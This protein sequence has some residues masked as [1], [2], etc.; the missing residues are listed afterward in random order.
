MVRKLL[1][2]DQYVL[3]RGGGI[4]LIVRIC[5]LCKML[6]GPIQQPILP[7]SGHHPAQVS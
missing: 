2:E 1:Q 7:P 6:I 5:V 4:V 3:Q